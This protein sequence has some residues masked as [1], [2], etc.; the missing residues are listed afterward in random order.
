MG[1]GSLIET[2]PVLLWR[3]LSGNQPATRRNMQEIFKQRDANPSPSRPVS[4]FNSFSC[5]GSV[6]ARAGIYMEAG[7]SFARCE[8]D[9]CMTEP[10]VSHLNAWEI[11]DPA[12]AG[13]ESYP[14]GWR[15]LP[16]RRRD[17]RFSPIRKYL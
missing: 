12:R 6:S 13:G 15:E 11:Y 4:D 5:I 10:T 8:G 2:H 14:S 16:R 7:E 1:V 9:F 17:K 3:H